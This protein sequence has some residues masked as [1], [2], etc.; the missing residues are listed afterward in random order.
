MR[1]RIAD[2]GVGMPPEVLARAFDPFF[3]TKET[4]KGS[5]LGLA[6]VYGFATQAGGEVQD[7]KQPGPRHDR[8]PAAAAHPWRAGPARARGGRGGDR[9]AGR[10]LQGRVLLVEDDPEVASLTAE[11]LRGLGLA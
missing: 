1:L 3:T 7:R 4:G 5:G 10:R 8:D 11:M 9:R 6:Q 2:S